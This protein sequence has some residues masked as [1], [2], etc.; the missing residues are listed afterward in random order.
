MWRYLENLTKQSTQEGLP[1]SLNPPKPSEEICS[2]KEARQKWYQDP[3]STH[4]FYTPFEGVNPNVRIRESNQPHLVHG[5][6]A[7]IDHPHSS[8]K[9]DEYARKTKPSWVEKSLGGKWRFLFTIM[10]PSGFLIPKDDELVKEFLQL[11]KLDLGLD[12]IQGLDEK[13]WLSPT[14]LYC[15]G[16]EP[17][18]GCGGA[19]TV[20][21]LS[22]I[23]AQAIRSLVKA[24]G[25]PVVALAEIEKLIKEKW[26]TW[27]WPGEFKLGS[28]GPSWW[29]EG[30]TS[31]KSAVVRPDGMYTFAAH[32]VKA[33]YSWDDILGEGTVSKNLQQKVEVATKDLWFDGRVYFTPKPDLGF[34]DYTETS[35]RRLLIERGLLPKKNPAGGL[36]ELEKAIYH[37]EFNRR[38]D[39]AG[40][41][42]Y[43]PKGLINLD[44]K[45]HLNTA[46]IQP[47]KPA[48]GTQKWGPQGNF[49][50]IS[51]WYDT[52]FVPRE[53]QLYHYLSWLHVWYRDTLEGQPHQG[54]AIF[55]L[56]GTNGG[57]TLNNYHVVGPLMG[58]VDDASKFLTGAD[59]FGGELFKKPL[60]AIDD[61]SMAIN[62]Q[63]IRE[64]TGLVKRTVSNKMHKSHEKFKMPVLLI[65]EGR[66]IVTANLDPYSLSILPSTD[67]SLLEK[68]CFYRWFDWDPRTKTHG[69]P[70]TFFPKDVETI[71][72]RELPYFARYVH[73]FQVP[74]EFVGANRFRL[75]HYQEPSLLREAY[76]NSGLANIVEVLIMFLEGYEKLMETPQWR[77]STAELFSLLEA[78]V[79]TRAPFRGI[80]PALLNK[81]LGTLIGVKN[82]K[83]EVEVED[84]GDIRT[85]TLTLKKEEQNDK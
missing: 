21:Y 8:E 31:P 61:Q 25:S 18:V 70:K 44:G 15:R 2:S 68:V 56:G 20:P 51:Y 36:N 69:L 54:H 50:F 62:L 37:L 7:D 46:D 74:D 6:V 23:L 32:A 39:S 29:I 3:T 12:E 83:L 42:I 9:I 73:D 47:M 85:W 82:S 43:R 40:P 75:N 1:W 38:V 77:G 64:F 10:E 24:A 49:P 5:F 14:Q 52:V 11:L 13:A 67:E 63:S 35:V 48:S 41:V 57:K 34:W 53:P 60:W 72:S 71:L 81:Y 30:S 79:R 65:W 80:N 59:G 4:V 45:R 33:F 84:N 28:Q 16:G 78:D 27:S 76:N 55:I 22:G 66:L 58:G 19:L 17:M 26:P